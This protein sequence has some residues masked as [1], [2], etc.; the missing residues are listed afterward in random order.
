[1][2]TKM[3]KVVFDSMSDEELAW[4]VMKPILLPLRGQSPAVK[5]KVFK[6]L[7]ADQQS[8]FMIRVLYDHACDSVVEYYCWIAHLLSESNTWEAVKKGVRSFGAL[9]MLA[10]LEKTEMYME[11]KNRQDTGEWRIAIPQDLEHDTELQVQISDLFDA[12]HEHAPALW[13]LV[14]DTIRSRPDQFVVFED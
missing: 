1:M 11:S 14:G 8:L 9:N 10:V 13:K 5:T 12:F 2:L 4:E 3:K 7:S 6:E